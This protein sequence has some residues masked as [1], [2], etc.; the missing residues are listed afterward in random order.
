MTAQPTRTR[1]QAQPFGHAA[2]RVPVAADVS[3]QAGT[4]IAYEI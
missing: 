1:A 3:V 2:G 4:V